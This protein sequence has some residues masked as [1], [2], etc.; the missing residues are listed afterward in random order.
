MVAV[1]VGL[2]I[3]SVQFLT[4]DGLPAPFRSLLSKVN[5]YNGTIS[6]ELAATP[7]DLSPRDRVTWWV[8]HNRDTILLQARRRK[9]SAAAIAGVVAF[10]ALENPEPAFTA[11]LSR[12]DGPGKVHYEN[13]RFG[14]G[15]SVAEAVEIEGY[16]PRRSLQ[17]RES[18]LSTNA[19]SI[20]YIA[21]ILR[22]Y[23]DV[24]APRGY[25]VRC[26]A[27]LLATFYTGWDLRS[28]ARHLRAVKNVELLP[29]RAGKWLNGNMDFLYSALRL[30][31]G[32]CY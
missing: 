25:R 16:L 32:S 14:K 5:P 26:N 19:G 23:A 12:Y 7:K 13:K 21:T 11:F 2:L 4:S 1:F 8:R 31:V 20:I 3:G 9:V 28:L 24:A 27:P 6:W 15:I 22:A 29:N 18:I 30:P 10:E 17:E